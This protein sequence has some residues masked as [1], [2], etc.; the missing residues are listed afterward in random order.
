MLAVLRAEI[1]ERDDW[2]C[3]LCGDRVDRDTHWNA[4]LA[5]SL[6]HI[7]PQSL[8]GS[9]EPENL[10]TAHR[11]CNTLRGARIEDEAVQVTAP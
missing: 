1:Y 6:D 2:I 11:V 9:D 10:R 4:P 7:A 5:P 8:G 3:Q